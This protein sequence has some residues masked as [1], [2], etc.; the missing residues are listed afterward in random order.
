MSWSN[1]WWGPVIDGDDNDVRTM[2][3]KFVAGHE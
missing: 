3:D 1:G 2:L